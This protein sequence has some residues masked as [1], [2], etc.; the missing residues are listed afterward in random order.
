MPAVAIYMRVSSNRQETRSQEADLMAYKD[1]AQAKGET[2]LVC[3]KNHPGRI[4]TDRNGRSCGERCKLG[5][6]RGL[7][8]GV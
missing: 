1:A 8:F 7:L 5:P 2:V 3:V 4:T 6:S